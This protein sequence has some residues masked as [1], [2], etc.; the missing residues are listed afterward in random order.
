MAKKRILYP[1]VY[2][3][4][5]YQGG[6]FDGKQYAWKGSLISYTYKAPSEPCIDEEKNIEWIENKVFEDTLTFIGYERGRSS[7]VMRFKGSDG[8]EYNMFLTDTDDLIKSEDIIGGKVT[9]KWTFCKRG[10]NYG[11]KLAK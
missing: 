7:A 4:K 8:A 2:K 5:F 11:I 1:V 9:A 3:D 6:Y 10:E